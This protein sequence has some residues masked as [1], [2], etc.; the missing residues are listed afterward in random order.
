MKM[1]CIGL[2]VRRP[3]D[4][5]GGG[6]DESVDVGDVAQF[7]GPLLV[8]PEISAA[9]QVLLWVRNSKRSRQKKN[10]LDHSGNDNLQVAA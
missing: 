7:V 5:G 2:V 1:V 6:E 3:D 9:E 10:A 4:V 8:I